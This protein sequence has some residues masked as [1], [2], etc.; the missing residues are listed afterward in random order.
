[1]EKREILILKTNFYE[2]FLAYKSNKK[3]SI[4][5]CILMMFLFIR[6]ILMYQK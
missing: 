3:K 4:F 2:S 6:E 5:Y 1:M